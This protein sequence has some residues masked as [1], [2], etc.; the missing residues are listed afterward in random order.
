MIRMNSSILKCLSYIHQENLNLLISPTK[1]VYAEAEC[2]T[3][4]TIEELYEIEEANFFLFIKLTHQLQ[5]QQ[6]PNI[7]MPQP[8]HASTI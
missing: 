7:V 2:K 3:L 4:H 6:S 5:D 8:L 1:D